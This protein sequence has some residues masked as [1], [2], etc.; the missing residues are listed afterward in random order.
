MIEYVEDDVDEFP[1]SYFS[2]SAARVFDK[3]NNGKSG[4]L[5]FS[6][7]VD[8]I[9]TLGWG[10]YSENLEVN[11]QKLDPSGSV[12]L[13]CFDYVRWYVDKDVSLYSTKEEDSLV[14]WGWKVILM[15]FQ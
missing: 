8:S 15:D 5:P 1:D 10:F 14:I 3:T 12:S 11:L 9:E 2:K 7:F 13:E 6:K 4:F